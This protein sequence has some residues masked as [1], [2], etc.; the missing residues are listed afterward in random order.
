[1]MMLGKIL[2]NLAVQVRHQPYE[3]ICASLYSAGMKHSALQG[4]VTNPH[5]IDFRILLI[6]TNIKNI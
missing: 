5:D 6:T 2:S 3:R 4:A 1:M